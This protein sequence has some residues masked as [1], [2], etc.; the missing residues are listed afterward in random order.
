MYS[1]CSLLSMF[2]I[3]DRIKCALCAEHLNYQ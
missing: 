3:V 2:S 1:I